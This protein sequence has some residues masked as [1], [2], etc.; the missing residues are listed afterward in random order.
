MG[1]E[2]ARATGQEDAPTAPAGNAPRAR[3][4]APPGNG[5]PSQPGA[6][7][8]RAVV[9]LS[10]GLD[11]TTS[12]AQA[13][14]D[15]YELYALSFD[16][17]QRHARELDAA[18]AVAA[19]LRV[20]RHEILALPLA[21]LGGSALTDSRIAVPDGPA[22]TA[23]IG[24]A[25]PVTYVPGRN[26]VFLAVALAYAEV[27]GA[28]AIY[29]GVNALDYSGYPDCRPEYLAAMQEVARLATKQGVDGHAPRLVAPLVRMTKKQIVEAAVRLAAPI[30][31]TWSCYRGGEQACGRCESC[32]LR[33][34]G[35]A[36]AGFQ[37]P[38][39]YE[40]AS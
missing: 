11:S 9:L 34:R 35:F 5:Q 23:A 19:A 21:A 36:D 25:I 7:P 17:G 15:G 40:A 4:T 8:R 39:E 12:A 18:R 29:L 10:G 2:S 1:R 6:P 37:D 24:L 33:R 14:A 3:P 13:A 27:V 28:D 38:Q 22:S 30:E 16:Y 31:N 20:A 26:T 32:R